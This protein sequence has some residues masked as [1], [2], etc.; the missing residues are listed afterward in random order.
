MRICLY[1]DVSESIEHPG[2]F[3]FDMFE[4]LRYLFTSDTLVEISSCPASVAGI[5]K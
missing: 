1:N 5:G 3:S 4:R 2:Q